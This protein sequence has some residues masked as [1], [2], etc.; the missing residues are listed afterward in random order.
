M[1]IEVENF[2]I[3][4]FPFFFRVHVIHLPFS[5]YDFTRGAGKSLARPG[6]KQARKHVRD[7]R[8]FKN[9]ETRV[10]MKF[11]FPVSRRRKFTP[12][13]PKHWLVSFLVGLRTYQHPC[14]TVL[15]LCSVDSVG[16]IR[17]SQLL[18]IIVWFMYVSVS[19]IN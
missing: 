13:W 14:I 16:T 19:Y 9:I 15:I 17:Y 18:A 3:N 1:Y 6:M 12:F 10:V 2:Q 11:F 8:D 4:T 7:T 5:R